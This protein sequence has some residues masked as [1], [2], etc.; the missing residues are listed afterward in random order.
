MGFFDFILKSLS[1]DTLDN[2][3]EKMREKVDSLEDNPRKQVRLDSRRIDMVNEISSRRADK[4]P[5]GEHGWYLP[6]DDD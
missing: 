3:E 5:K 4:L 1:E 6:E 2:I